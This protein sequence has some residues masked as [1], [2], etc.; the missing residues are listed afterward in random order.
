MGQSEATHPVAA[1]LL[2][3]AY[4][5]PPD[6]SGGADAHAEHVRGRGAGSA[7]GSRLLLESPA[8]AR[9][10]A[11][12]ATGERMTIATMDMQ[13]KRRRGDFLARNPFA[14]PYTLGF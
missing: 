3:L 14:R 1:A 12:A 4:R 5:P 7:G 9:R 11:P 6:E 2:S 13:T 10:T 8:R